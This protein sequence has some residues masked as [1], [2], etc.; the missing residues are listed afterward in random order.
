MVDGLICAGKKIHEVLI[1]ADNEG[2]ERDCNNYGH[3][4]INL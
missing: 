2:A 4:R 1:R 3:E